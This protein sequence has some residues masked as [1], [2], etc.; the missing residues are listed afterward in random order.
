MNVFK[1]NS[2]AHSYRKHP[3]QIQ[4]YLVTCGFFSV[5]LSQLTAFTYESCLCAVCILF[6]ALPAFS[7]FIQTCSLN[8]MC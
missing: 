5:A 3:E 8:T 1:I 4:Y 2:H 6:T 7:Y